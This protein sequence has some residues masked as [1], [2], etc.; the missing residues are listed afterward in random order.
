M[1]TPQTTSLRLHLTA[2]GGQKEAFLN[3]NVPHDATVGELVAEMLPQMELP[4]RDPQGRPLSY[5]ARLER[6]GRH[7]QGSERLTEALQ[8]DDTIQLLPNVD[9][10][11]GSPA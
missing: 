11:G 5:R 8:P 1:G 4:V 7:L 6:E 3:Q 10:G 2:A 9:A